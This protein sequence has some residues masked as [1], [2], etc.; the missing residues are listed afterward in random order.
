[1]FLSLQT[2]GSLEERRF[3]CKFILISIVFLSIL[4]PAGIHAHSSVVVDSTGVE[5]Q[6][7]T[8]DRIIT[9]APN[10]AEICLLLGLRPNLVAVAKYSEY[11]GLESV[12]RL[13]GWKVNFERI[14][15]F[16]PDL[17]ITTA[18]GNTK[19]V[20]ARLRSLGVNVFYTEQQSVHQIL[21]T[22][23]KL[24]QLTESEKAA[25]DFLTQS[26]ENL[27]RLSENSQSSDAPRPSVLYLLW[28]KPI[29]APGG[30]NF[31]DE[32]IKLSGGEPLFT[33]VDTQLLKPTLEEII[34]RNPDVIFLP[35]GVLASD[36]DERW[37]AVPAV[38][39]GKV[40][41]LDEDLILRPGPGIFKGIKILRKATAEALGN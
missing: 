22:V 41:N 34:I 26:T 28:V 13:D 39:A 36:L 23:K 11:P 14:I 35:E 7:K 5:H 33:D 10:L 19:Q 6:V 16:K 29:M 15:S 20:V 12:P 1:M 25:E 30:G 17:V 32:I 40:F 24:G 4:I 9:L 3:S 37:N 31:L 18:S 8:Y 2:R 38:K 21:D 27:R